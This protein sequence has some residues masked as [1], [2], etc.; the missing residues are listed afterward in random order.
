ML[1][2]SRQARATPS[3][4]RQ[5]GYRPIARPSQRPGKA[6]DSTTRSGPETQRAETC[7]RSLLSPMKACTMR[8][9]ELVD[10]RPH[11]RSKD[12]RRICDRHS[13]PCRD[14]DWFE[15]NL[16]VGACAPAS[17]QGA[18]RLRRHRSLPASGH[19]EN[20]ILRNRFKTRR[21][22]GFR[23]FV[24]IR[25]L[26]RARSRRNS[27]CTSAWA[28]D[29]RCADALSR[30]GGQPE[31]QFWVAKGSSTGGRGRDPSIYRDRHGQIRTHWRIQAV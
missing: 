4:S 15:R 13:S 8:R 24:A 16:A 29:R 25:P 5:A 26:A 18:C 12:P 21:A 7:S 1:P 6:R 11:M 30:D 23:M 28:Q 2:Q 9:I 27:S 14:Q 17:G 3:R 10:L 20:C 31:R 22:V 19:P